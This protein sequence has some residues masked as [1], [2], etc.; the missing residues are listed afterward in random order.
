MTPPQLC[1]P[2]R[3]EPL[4]VC[5]SRSALV[6]VDMQNGFATPGGYLDRAGF[7]I[8]G[9]RAVVTNC[10]S[11][12]E[13]TRR[14]GMRIVYL[15]MGW[16][17]DM[18][19]AGAVGGGMWHKSVA[20][21]FM[22]ARPE[23]AGTAIIRG[24]WDYAIVDELAPREGDVVIAKTRLS[25]FF[26]TNLDSMLRA[27]QIET[28][29]FVGI[30]TN[31]CVEATMRDALYRDYRCLLIEDASNAAGPE[32]VHRATLFNVETFLGWVTT[33]EEFC[34]ALQGAA[35]TVAAVASAA[36]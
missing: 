29:A 2:A 9:A 5:P 16:H 26:E 13:G 21:R 8:S 19:D 34:R 15:Q 31:V 25:G 6:V 18:R 12:L 33:T 23:H 1:I 30:A 32:F 20:W 7:D 3:P 24:T 14:A 22:R 28:L 10:R 27:L 36:R 4:L 17:R 11:I 35:P